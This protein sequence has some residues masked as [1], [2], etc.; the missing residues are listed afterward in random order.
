MERWKALGQSSC[1]RSLTIRLYKENIN[2]SRKEFCILKKNTDVL[3]IGGSAA[4]LAAANSVHAWYPGKQITIIRNVSYTVVPCGIPYIYGYLNVVEKDIISDE[5]FINKGFAFIIG[6]VEDIDRENHI[7]KLA[8]GTEVAYEKLIIATG[9]HPILPPIAGINLPNVY[10]IRKDPEFLDRIGQSVDAAKDVVIIG[11]GFIGVEMAEQVK[12]RGDYNVSLVEAMPHCL[13]AACEENA[14]IAVEEELKKMGVNVLT[15]TMV[16]AITGTEKVEG[17]KL[18]N[19]DEIKA[20]VVIL[21]IGAIPNTNLAE[22]IGLEVDGKMGIKVDGYFRTSDRDIF[23]CGDCCTKFSSITGEPAAIRLASVAASEGMIAGSNLYHLKRRGKGAVGAFATKV[24]DVS[25]AAAGF[26]E[27]MCQEKNLSYYAGEIVA[28]DRH[29]GSL[30]GCTMK[31]RVKLLFDMQRDRLIGA[32]VIGGDQAADMLNV[33]ALGI[34]QGVTPE[35]LALAQ[36]AT[37]PLLTG[38]P[39]VYQVMWAA[40]NAILN[41]RK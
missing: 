6:D 5:G 3:I 29:P 20:D 13:Q 34:Q 7:A 11:G 10:P 28:P 4:G 32:H 39:L 27:K 31:T 2:L 40:E 16:E 41:R 30:P 37:H 22:K 26:T 9:S 21:G 19:G 38:S 33:L 17:V 15:S 14:G 36:Y 24:G 8:D 23:A 12:M 18:S 1:V 25:V 35:E